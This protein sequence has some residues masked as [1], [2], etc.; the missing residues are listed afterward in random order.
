[1]RLAINGLIYD[2][3]NSYYVLNTQNG[4]PIKNWPFMRG[5]GGVRWGTGGGGL[6]SDF[7]SILTAL[8]LYAKVSPLTMNTEKILYNQQKTPFREFNILSS[9]E[10]PDD[11]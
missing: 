8:A 10:N 4:S 11:Y 5:W 6:G 7:H 2:P 1:M 3:V 9:L